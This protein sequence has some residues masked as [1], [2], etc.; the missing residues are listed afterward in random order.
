MDGMIEVRKESIGGNEVN[1]LNARD[2]HA[3]LESKQQFADWIKS[4]I[5][6][7]GFMEGIDFITFHNSMK[8]E[9]AYINTKEYT[10][11]LDMAK[12]LAMVE[13]NKKGRMA[14]QYFIE[15]ERRLKDISRPVQIQEDPMWL[16]EAQATLKFGDLLGMPKHITVGETAKRVRMLDGPDFTSHI[17]ALP[18]SQNILPEEMM[19][20]PTPLGKMFGL[21][22]IEMNRRLAEWNWQYRPDG[23]TW[24]RTQQ[25][26][27]YSSVHYWAKNNKTGY[28]L[29][30]NVEAVRARMREAQNSQQS[31][32]V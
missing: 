26:E 6:K 4:R 8:A 13:K 3:F 9:N 31:V 5:T 14:R 16:K 25:G 19:L 20:E 2:F 27:P 1:A 18:S 15:C 28:N 12:Q 29:K 30:W 11:S 32:L 23:V 21:S 22:A 10:I 7:Y 17:G 24:T